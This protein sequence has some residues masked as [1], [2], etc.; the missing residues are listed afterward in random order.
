MWLLYS[1]SYFNRKSTEYRSVKHLKII[2]L[3]D[4]LIFKACKWD[5]FMLYMISKKFG[6][7]FEH[8]WTNA[9]S[10]LYK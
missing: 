6:T 5:N 2:I 7:S 8:A 9:L 1:K 4:S 10:L 3:Q